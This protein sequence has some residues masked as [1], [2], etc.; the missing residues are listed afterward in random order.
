M[1]KTLAQDAVEELAPINPSPKLTNTPYKSEKSLMIVVNEVPNQSVALI[2]V[3]AT[4]EF[5]IAMMHDTS[6]YSIACRP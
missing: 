5:L 1:G 2:R 3:K 6:D 4:L